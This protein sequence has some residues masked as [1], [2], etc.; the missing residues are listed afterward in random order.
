VVDDLR[1]VLL[2]DVYGWGLCVE[3]LLALYPRAILPALPRAR[4]ASDRKES[5]RLGGELPALVNVM[6]AD[7]MFQNLQTT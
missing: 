1:P 6:E 5:S 7:E 4:W 3:S 2:S